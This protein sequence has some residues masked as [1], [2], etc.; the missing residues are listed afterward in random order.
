MALRLPIGPLKTRD[1]NPIPT[2][3]LADDLATA[4]SGPIP[5]RSVALNTLY[6]G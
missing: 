3:P 4:T 5:L 2:S 6:S 1:A